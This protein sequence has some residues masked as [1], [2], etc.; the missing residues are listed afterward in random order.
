MK[1]LFLS[2]GKIKESYLQ[3]GIDDFSKRLQHYVK[4]E[5]HT[6]KEKKGRYSVKQQKDEEGRQLL[7]KVGKSSFVIALDPNGKQTSSE[8]LANYLDNWEMRGYGA[9]CF[10]IGGPNGLSDRVLE[11]ADFCLSLSK[12]TL[13]HEMSRLVLL[14][15]LYRAYTIKKGTGYHK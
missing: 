14:E 3:K 10:L 1:F 4:V 15:Q 5:I 7:A 13:T 12:M 6:V 8:G 2:P 9:V 11:R